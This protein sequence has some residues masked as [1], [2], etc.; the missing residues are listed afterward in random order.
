MKKAEKFERENNGEV[1]T[2]EEEKKNLMAVLEQGYSKRKT[3]VRKQKNKPKKFKNRPKTTQ[4]IK[5]N[6]L[7]EKEK[8][9]KEDRMQ[10]I[11]DPLANHFKKSVCEYNILKSILMGRENINF[12]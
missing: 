11:E 6:R 2:W 7:T 5:R 1:L 9:E 12:R 8:K 3:G 4:T 10:K